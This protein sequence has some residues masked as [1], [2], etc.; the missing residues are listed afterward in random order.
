[1]VEELRWEILDILAGKK[2]YLKTSKIDAEEI[3]GLCNTRLDIVREQLT[4]MEHLSL[5]KLSETLGSKYTAELT[6]KGLLEHK[7]ARKD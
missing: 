1:M 2:G 3:A 5:V 4:K 7:R 6:I